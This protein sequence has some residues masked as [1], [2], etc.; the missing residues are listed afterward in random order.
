MKDFTTIV[1]DDL[2]KNFTVK[3]ELVDEITMEELRAQL[4]KL[5]H[6]KETMED[7]LEAIDIR[8]NLIRTALSTGKAEGDTTLTG[9]KM[10]I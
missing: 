5:E 1:R 2:R 3:R 10:P 4:E 9:I 7:Q 8:L 6:T